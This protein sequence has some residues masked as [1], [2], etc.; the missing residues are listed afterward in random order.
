MKAR[1][2]IVVVLPVFL[3][4][5]SCHRLAITDINLFDPA[6]GLMMPN[7][8]ILVEGDRVT[9]IGK[10]G[11]EIKIPSF[12]KI[13]N[14][15]GKWIIPGLIDA[16]SHLVFL[17]DSLNIKGEEMMPLYLGNGVTSVRD[18]GDGIIEQK[19]VA[20]FAAAHRETCPTVFLCSPLIDGAHPYHGAD[21]VSMPVTDPARVPGF[22][23]SLVAYG[24]STLKLYVY[25]DSAVFHKVIDEGH[26]HGL[27]VSAHLPSNVVKTQDA[28]NW[29][30]DVIE[31]VF[32]TPDDS[33]LIAQ[34]VKQG[35]MLDPTLIVFKNMLLFNDQP[36]VYQNA[37]NSFM[38]DTVLKYWDTYRMNA[39]W[40]GSR[41]TKENFQSRLKYMEGYMNAA[42]R[43]YH[44][45]V[46]LLAGTDSPEPYCPPGFAL[47]D[48]L[49]LLVECG[50]SPAAAL[51]C[52][53]LNNAK[54]LKQQDNLGTIEV[55]KIADMVILDADPLTDIRNSRAINQVIHHGIVCDPKALLSMP[56]N[57]TSKKN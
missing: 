46:T 29:G 49:S 7:R 43:L 9:A 16:H 24:V 27:T 25:A 20:D 50:L 18:I 30:L 17:L 8:T 22:I 34:M 14:G 41:L 31:H 23:D 21:R 6:T 39:Q 1:P 15:S 51:K 10:P 32:G 5:Q 4:L 13:I 33:L 28:L 2:L 42:A 3:L 36:E 52:A 53:T 11:S 35:T 55:G 48:E 57:A 38:P 45:G 54:A 12:T 19:R 37:D 44:A 26:K 56:R 40:T 47:H